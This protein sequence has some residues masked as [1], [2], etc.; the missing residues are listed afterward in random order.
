MHM[1]TFRASSDLSFYMHVHDTGRLQG[2][3]YSVETIATRI[4]IESSNQ[5]PLGSR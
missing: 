5:S 4:I 2:V 1:E 3:V